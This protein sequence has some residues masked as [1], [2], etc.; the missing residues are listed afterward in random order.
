MSL[1]TLIRYFIS[2]P[3]SF[4]NLCRI[5]YSGILKSFLFGIGNIYII[6]MRRFQNDYDVVSVTLE[7]MSNIGA[8]F[9]PILFNLESKPLKTFN[10]PIDHWLDKCVLLIMTKI[11][12][13]SYIQ[14]P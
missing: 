6:N 9:E 3:R 2:H 12:M 1:F 5:K 14:K 11:Q 13:T 7:I 8:G 4:K 10:P